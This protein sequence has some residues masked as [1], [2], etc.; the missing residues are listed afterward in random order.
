[1][2]DKGERQISIP[3]K[4]EGLL[5]MFKSSSFIL[6]SYASFLAWPSGSISLSPIYPNHRPPG[7]PSSCF[8]APRQQ[9]Y[10]CRNHSSIQF[11]KPPLERFDDLG[12]P[13]PLSATTVPTPYEIFQLEKSAP[14]SKGRF[15]ELVKLYHPDWCSHDG[16]P[17]R[18]L[19]HGVRVERYRLAVAANCILSDPAKRKAYD[20]FGSGWEGHLDSVNSKPGRTHQSRGER[21]GFGSKNSPMNNA[22]WEDWEKWYE[23]EAGGKQEP[24][25][26][27]NGEFFSLV[28]AVVILGGLAQ[29]T[30]VGGSSIFL[31]HAEA[32]HDDCYKSVRNRKNTSHGL[33]NNNDRVE[34]FLRI[35]DPYGY[36]LKG[37]R[38][39][40]HG[41][42]LSSPTDRLD[43]NTDDSNG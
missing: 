22:T 12:W 9:V 1:M 43:D 17:S 21:S 39:E 3:T 19:S 30:R 34:R 33:E 27:S 5:I 15:Y 38:E 32:V 13:K 42:L 23:R 24:V 29:A 6:P 14:Y 35:R 16:N 10:Q 31:E 4:V 36:G 11:K 18:C 40:T 26:L 25:S 28:M 20:R 8:R 7:Q 41:S 37:S 2:R